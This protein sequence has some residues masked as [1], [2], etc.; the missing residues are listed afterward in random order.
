MDSDSGF[1]AVSWSLC[2]NAG[3]NSPKNKRSLQ[4]DGTRRAAAN[5]PLGQG[6]RGRGR[7][8]GCVQ[9]PNDIT[10][11]NFSRCA[12]PTLTR[13]LRHTLTSLPCTHSEGVWRLS[14]EAER[15]V[16]LCALVR[17]SSG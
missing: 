4:K 16:L 6:R 3:V 13:L 1:P 5:V 11:R 12:R 17:L 7:K 10:R 14:E 9:Q 8:E 2:M 15:R